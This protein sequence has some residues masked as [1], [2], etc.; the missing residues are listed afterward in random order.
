M[1]LTKQELSERRKARYHNDPEYRERVLTSA[2]RYHKKKRETDPEYA[3]KRSEYNKANA[4]YFNKKTKE[5][6]MKQPFHYA[7]KRL[8]LRAKQKGIPFDLD[9]QYLIDLWT[10][11][12]AIFN[13]VL[14]DPY[15]TT[16]QDPNKA[17]VDRVIPE[18][19][20]IKG[21]VK[22]VSNKA[23]I[24]KSFG[25]IEEHENVISYM[26]EHITVDVN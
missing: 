12:C 8:R 3:K 25:T 7:F 26:K 17:T 11:K 23:N 5:Y 2:K 19:G 18:I 13:T 15:S 10:G 6:N 9:E 14:C 24:I 1:A 21:N 20:Y 22:W 16:T 4:A